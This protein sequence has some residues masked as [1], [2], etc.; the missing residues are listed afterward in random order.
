MEENQ[1]PNSPDQN[2]DNTQPNNDQKQ[3]DVESADVQFTG[4]A[5]NPIQ[6]YEDDSILDE[7]PQRSVSWTAPEFIEHK[8][9]SSW[10][11]ILAAIILAVCVVVYFIDHSIFTIVMIILIGIAFGVIAG[12]PPKI[13]NFEISNEGILIGDKT[14]RYSQYKSFSVIPEASYGSIVFNPFK[15]FEFPITIYYDPVKEN[16]ILEILA[17]YLPNIKPTNDPIEQLMRKVRF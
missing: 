12:R 5:Q 11:L 3:D 17:D 2:S 16:E 8:K 15:R 4:N 1:V 13:V 6:N 7:V 10:F 14:I 9:S